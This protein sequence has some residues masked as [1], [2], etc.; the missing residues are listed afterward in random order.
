MTT[1]TTQP[2]LEPRVDLADKRFLVVDDFSTMRRIVSGLIRGLGGQHII[3]AEDG[4]EALKKLARHDV[5][6]IISDWNMPH[7]NG[8]ELLK[9]IRAGEK[10]AAVPFLLVTAEARRENI[11]DAVRAGADGYIVK[12]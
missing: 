5:D 4:A 9:E 3:E 2:E 10:N 6:F 11:L 1:T 12:P 7:L 8:L